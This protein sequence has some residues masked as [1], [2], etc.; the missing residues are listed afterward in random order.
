MRHC[1]SKGSIFAGSLAA[2]QEGLE[3]K[4]M[5][6]KKKRKRKSNVSEDKQ[7]EGSREVSILKE[8]S[9]DGVLTTLEVFEDKEAAPKKLSRASKRNR[10][11]RQKKAPEGTK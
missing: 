9:K 8:S 7:K 6:S 4:D 10:R 1:S 2:Q 5:C 11:K 3:S